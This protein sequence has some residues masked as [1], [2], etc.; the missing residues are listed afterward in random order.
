MALW[1]ADQYSSVPL[2]S[3]TATSWLYMSEEV[4]QFWSAEVVG[5]KIASPAVP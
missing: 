3:G 1:P 5:S 2:V 4:S